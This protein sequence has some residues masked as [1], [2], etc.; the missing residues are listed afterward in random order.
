MLKEGIIWKTLNCLCIQ[1]SSWRALKCSVY[2]CSFVAIPIVKMM[3][4][5]SWSQ[6]NL[7]IT[8]SPPLLRGSPFY[9]PVEL[10]ASN[11]CVSPLK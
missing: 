2:W 4:I 9:A 10:T 7:S 1:L 3:E 5:W 11:S 6:I 8:L